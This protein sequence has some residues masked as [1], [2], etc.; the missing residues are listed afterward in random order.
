MYVV[1]GN[2]FILYRVGVH[3]VVHVVFYIFFSVPVLLVTFYN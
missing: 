3:V 2:T 1:N